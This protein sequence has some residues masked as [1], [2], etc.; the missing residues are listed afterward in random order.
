MFKEF[1]KLLV[2]EY[3]IEVTRKGRL[4][5]RKKVY[6][7]KQASI[8]DIIKMIKIIDDQGATGFLKYFFT[9]V[10]KPKMTAWQSNKLKVENLI[11]ILNFIKKTY[12]KG[13]FQKNKSNNKSIFGSFIVAICKHGGVTFEEFMN[14]TYEQAS[15]I[16]DGVR[17]NANAQSK[18]GQAKNEHWLAKRDFEEEISNEEALAKIKKMENK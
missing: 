1:E 4:F 14:M 7:Y 18:K 16:S 3:E 13:F 5:T 2:K 6:Q 15:V 17:W 12:A 8:S 11:E 9:E 10:T